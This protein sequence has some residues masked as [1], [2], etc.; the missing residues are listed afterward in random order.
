[1]G[2]FSPRAAA[3]ILA[4][5]LISGSIVTSAEGHAPVLRAESEPNDTPS[6]ATFL[7]MVG[8][9]GIA[10]GIISSGDVDVWKF[11]VAATVGTNRVWILTDTGGTQAAGAT[12][13]DSII[14]LLAPDGVTVLE[15]DDNNGTGMVAT[16]RSRRPRRLRSPADL[17][18]RYLLHSGP[19][20]VRG[21][22]HR[23]VSSV[24]RG[25]GRFHSAEPGG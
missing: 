15:T 8:G 13:R 6:T 3:T 10:T 23:S 18:I 5:L 9:Y 19:G 14:E 17:S 22:D 7:P 2:C 25:A 20:R 12:S 21:S 24:R 16:A 4:T 11:T 1:M